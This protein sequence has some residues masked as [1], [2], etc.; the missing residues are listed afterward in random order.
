VL[1]ILRWA[2]S[3]RQLIPELVACLPASY[4]QY[5]E[6]FAGSAALF[7]AA[8]GGPASLGDTNP[9]VCNLYRVLQKHPRRL[10]KGLAELPNDSSGYYVA[11]QQFARERDSVR[12][13]VLFFYLNRFSFNGLYREN[14]NGV[15]N[16]PAG[17]E[18]GGMP[19]TERIMLASALLAECATI[20]EGDFELTISG[21]GARDLVYLDPPYWNISP[22]SKGMYGSSTES[23]RAL[24]LRVIAAVNALTRIGAYWI[25][26]YPST[27]DL[28]SLTRRHRIIQH[29]VARTIGGHLT[30]RGKLSELILTNIPKGN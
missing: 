29:R 9:H 2:G 12:S 24:L 15:F 18:T 13:A 25:L 1:P 28:A 5:F 14:K 26:S 22:K 21:A 4:G 6:P 30:R 3:K 7:F 27:S 8:V 11:R 17:T 19:N 10:L 20:Y 23:A 16:V